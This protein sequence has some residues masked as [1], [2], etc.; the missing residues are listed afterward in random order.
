M[1]CIEMKAKEYFFRRKQIITFMLVGAGTNFVDMA[2]F[3]VIYI[4]A[5]IGALSFLVANAVAFIL[6][7]VI[8]YLVN[9]RFTFGGKG[10]PSLSNGLKFIVLSSGSFLV[11]NSIMYYMI[12]SFPGTSGLIAINMIKMLFGFAAGGMN[13]VLFRG[14]VF[15]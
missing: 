4:L 14:L 12:N 13:F 7:T 1:E 2:L 8:K 6:T 3:N 11:F 5:G 15:S 10:G 9:D